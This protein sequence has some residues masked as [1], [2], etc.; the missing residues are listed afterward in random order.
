MSIGAWKSWP[1]QRS[2]NEA[3]ATYSV[4]H[5]TALSPDQNRCLPVRGQ[6]LGRENGMSWKLGNGEVMLSDSLYASFS[7]KRPYCRIFAS[8]AGSEVRT[9]ENRPGHGNIAN[10]AGEISKA[11]QLSLWGLGHDEPCET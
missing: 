7:L 5:A 3:E 6:I 4:A 10:Q 8:P 11:S 2:S 9:G 1:C